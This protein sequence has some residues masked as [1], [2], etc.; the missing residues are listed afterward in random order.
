MFL[1]LPFL[2][3]SRVIVLLLFSSFQEIGQSILVRQKFLL[4]WPLELSMQVLSLSFVHIHP[5]FLIPFFPFSCSHFD[6][7]DNRS[8][9]FH[10]CW[11]WTWRFL[12]LFDILFF[13]WVD[14]KIITSCRAS[15]CFQRETTPRKGHQNV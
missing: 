13:L 11:C 6:P 12:F 14:I 1:I 15:C 7:L 5:R 4:L 10:L 8:S 9:F 3:F 2:E